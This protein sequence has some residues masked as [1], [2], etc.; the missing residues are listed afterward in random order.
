MDRAASTPQRETSSC[1]RVHVT[2]RFG[3]MS[4]VASALH[5]V[6]GLWISD[7]CHGLDWRSE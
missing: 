6:D 1:P 5:P 4:S 3:G 2:S 7:V